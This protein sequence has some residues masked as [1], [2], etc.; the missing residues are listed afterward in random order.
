MVGVVR[1]QHDQMAAQWKR[2][3][4]TT[5]KKSR[6]NSEA[7]QINEKYKIVYRH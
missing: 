5:L 7:E 1:D 4:R 3:W 6:A 2:L